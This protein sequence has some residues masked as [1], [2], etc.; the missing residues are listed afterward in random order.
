MNHVTVLKTEAVD[1]LS[2]DSAAKVADCTLGAGGHSNEILSRLGAKGHLVSFDADPSAIAAFQSTASETATAH[3]LVAKNFSHIAA[4]S[5]DLHISSYDAI[6]ADLGWRSEQ[7]ESGNKGFSFLQD[8][9]LLMTYGEPGEYAFTAFDVVNDWAEESIADVIYGYGEERGARLI[10]AAIVAA[11]KEGEIATSLQLAAI[12]ESAV[13]TFY[14]RSK[15]HPATKTF[16]ALRI[17]VNDELGALD[18]LLED[19]FDLLAPGGRM[20]II[21][22]HSLEDRRVKQFFKGKAHDQAGVLVCKKPI[23][24]SQE[25]VDSNPRARSAK[26]RVI[27]RIV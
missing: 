18:T 12:V 14:K 9:Q 16:Q 5:T 25:E 4:V 2:L 6:L 3:T 7:F 15:I 8:E 22:F 19:G 26:L 13:G 17:A 1:Q 24:P 11:R 27:E 23:V 10:A 21:A 20:A